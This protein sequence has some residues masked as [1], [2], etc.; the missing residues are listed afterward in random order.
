QIERFAPDVVVS[1]YNLSSQALG[2]LRQRGELRTP[3]VTYVTDPGAHPYW[4]HPAVD[5]HLALLPETARALE[6]WG[7]RRTTVVAPVV[8]DRFADGTRCRQEAR[9]R[10][11]LPDDALVALVS[12][13][14]WAAGQVQRTV[15]LLA[16]TGT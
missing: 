8:G 6:S 16:R 11:G 12:A 10:T 15:E 13:G 3:V 1:V 9:R 4:V 5:L 7:A 14:S 2:R